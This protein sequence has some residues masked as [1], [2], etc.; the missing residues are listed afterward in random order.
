[1]DLE[2]LAIFVRVA[3]AGSLSKAS[4]QC[5]LGPSALSRQIAALEAEC[6]G[7]L[8]HR[9]GRGV[10]L[11]ELGESVLPKARDLLREAEVFKT[12]VSDASGVCRGTVHVG[13]VPAV[14]MPVMTRVVV[15]ARQQY[16]DVVIHVAAGL[17]GQV[18]QW[19]SDGTVDLGFVMRTNPPLGADRPVAITRM[20]LVGP[21]GDRL[22]AQPQ[23][24]L[25]RLDGAPM[26]QPATNTFRSMI[27]ELARQAGV[28]LNVVAEVDSMELTKQMVAAG[29]GYALLSATSVQ[30]E[31]KDG[32][33]TAT[34]VVD[35]E[36]VGY[37]HLE[38]STKKTV[39]L[40]TRK[41][42]RLIQEV[43]QEFSPSGDLGARGF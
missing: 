22:T 6:R 21:P 18:D 11:T 35:P 24:R 38:T 37:I 10:R 8:L 42:Y 15:R 19:L 34:P 36:V 9:T 3:E 14:A 26:I 33:L 43:T 16:P 12:I 41:I 13:T 23:I 1:M 7:R 27:A 39:S 29:V 25:G 32:R 28:R 4:L 17:S 31:V 20:C 5:G 40:A 2:Q 30:E